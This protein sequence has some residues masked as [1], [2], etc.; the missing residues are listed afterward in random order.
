MFDICLVSLQNLT[1]ND[2]PYNNH[3]LF[4][5]PKRRLSLEQR[6]RRNKR[7]RANLFPR[8]LKRDPRRNYAQMFINVFNLADEHMIQRYLDRYYSPNLQMAKN[9]ADQKTPSHRYES[10]GRF[11]ITNFLNICYSSMPD[12]TL[13]LL[14]SQVRI[15]PRTNTSV[16]VMKVRLAGTMVAFRSQEDYDHMMQMNQKANDVSASEITPFDLSQDIVILQ[17]DE[18]NDENKSLDD[19]MAEFAASSSPS[20]SSVSSSA[21]SD[22]D[23][24]YEQPIDPLTFNQYHLATPLSGTFEPH[25]SLY[26]N[27][28]HHIERFEMLMP[29]TC[30]FGSQT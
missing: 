25:I 18:T 11:L 14:Q 22:Y 5:K 2:F 7:R 8:I 30:C 12:V 13:T 10:R 4:L 29:S 26:L 17:D 6:E 15:D 9:F 28:N 3:N 23:I 20:S 19:S 24:T 27:A 21:A 16:I 1:D